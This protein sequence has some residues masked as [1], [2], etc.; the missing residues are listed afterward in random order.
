[1][2]KSETLSIFTLF[3]TKGEGMKIFSLIVS[4]I[5]INSPVLI[6]ADTW[7]PVPP[8]QIPGSAP[9]A[10]IVSASYSP[11]LGEFFV[12]WV[13]GS[14]NNPLYAIFNGTT[15]TAPAVI[16]GG[17]LASDTLFSSFSS[18]LGKFLV[19]WTEL[20]SQN[21]MYATFNGVT[22]SAPATIPASL[23]VASGSPVV[24][25]FDPTDG[26]FLVTWIDSV[27]GNPFY[28]T[29][30]GTIW[31]TPT[32]IPGSL[33]GVPNSG[34]IPIFGSL[35]G[36][37]LVTWL[38]ATSNFPFYALFNGSTWTAP[39]AIPGSIP[40]APDNPVI[41]SYDSV[42]GLFLV[43][44]QDSTNPYF[45]IYNGASWTTPSAIPSA[46][47]AGPIVFSSFDSRSD[48][49][50]ITW[51][52]TATLTPFY[53]TFDGLSW[54]TP[55]TIPSSLMANP[56]I[57]SAAAPDEFLVTW[58]LPTNEPFYSTFSPSSPVTIAGLADQN[59]SLLQ[60]ELF[61]V[62]RWTAPSGVSW[63]PAL[64]ELYRDPGLT[65]LAGSVPATGPLQFVDHN[66]Q[67]D[68]LYTYYLVAV[69]TLDVSHFLG[70]V[71]IRSE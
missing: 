42:L 50:L 43:T 44:W 45:A 9:T 30:N 12:G 8:I 22:W 58:N 67:R 29:F 34:V 69:D 65:D 21:P 53:T 3:L 17:S 47:P 14:S 68:T 55:T 51:Q 64:Y 46:M 48:K 41:S 66:R 10:N 15:W 61:N 38:D 5:C 35:A 28:A 24:S 16:P 27:S 62:V 70:S 59:R 57:L 23:P 6:H 56:P 71:T 49:F 32:A 19:T 11:S 7:N 63:T 40:I 33:P 54:G 4:L 39:A 52:D 60:T 36:E 37:F 31:S 20:G 13:D 26:E 25:S 2:T 1:L 18:T